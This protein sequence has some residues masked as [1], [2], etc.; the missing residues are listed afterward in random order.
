MASAIG[1]GGGSAVRQEKG[2]S[3]FL[4]SDLPP[5]VPAPFFVAH[6]LQGTGS[7]EVARS[8]LE[9]Y[10]VE[11]FS[12]S[13][14]EGGRSVPEQEQI[15]KQVVNRMVRG[16]DPD[17]SLGECLPEGAPETTTRNRF[18][19]ACD[20]ERGASRISPNAQRMSKRRVPKRIP[21]KRSADIP[22]DRSVFRCRE[23][24]SLCK[25]VCFAHKQRMV[26]Y[27]LQYPDRPYNTCARDITKDC[28]TFDGLS[29]CGTT[30]GRYVKN[31]YED[32]P[33]KT[34]V[35]PGMEGMVDYRRM[36]LALKANRQIP[37]TFS[38]YLLRQVRKGPE[39]TPEQER[40]AVAY[41]MERRSR[42]YPQCAQDI[43]RDYTIL[44]DA[45]ISMNITDR[46]LGI[47]VQNAYENHPQTLA[48]P[49]TMKKMID[50][51]KLLGELEQTERVDSDLFV[52]CC[53]GRIGYVH[54]EK[55]TANEVPETSCREEG[56]VTTATALDSGR[57]GEAG[58]SVQSEWE[59]TSF[60]S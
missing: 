23:T 34:P 49:G 35:P 50:Y 32:H 39:M 26:S 43:K 54:L 16:P 1:E 10:S 33:N 48:V 14:E 44:G 45:G 31:A 59:G 60:P 29:V 57:E 24:V 15:R 58:G 5:T 36:L 38:G 47:C 19:V 40:R 52:R 28:T 20:K 3:V 2:F 46:K 18:G 11:G 55:T 51:R 12:E 13:R 8:S 30:L 21:E 41:C 42:S 56:P 17:K 4:I 25:R 37:P 22:E 6:V 9:W 7:G 27:C 53:K